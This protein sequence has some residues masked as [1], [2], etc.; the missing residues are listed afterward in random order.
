MFIIGSIFFLPEVDY[1]IAGSWLFVFSSVAFLGGAIIN[2]VMMYNEASPLMVQLKNFTAIN[3][4]VGSAM[5]IVG[6]LTTF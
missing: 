5:F 6:S 3:F 4:I 2:V 1:I